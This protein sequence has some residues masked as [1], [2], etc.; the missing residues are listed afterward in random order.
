MNMRI[1]A[2]KQCGKEEIWKE[3]I[4]N[5]FDEIMTLRLPEEQRLVFEATSLRLAHTSGVNFIAPLDAVRKDLGKF[6]NLKMPERYLMMKEIHILFRP[7]SGIPVQILELYQEVGKAAAAYIGGKAKDDITEYLDTLPAEAISERC[8]MMTELAGIMRY[9]P[10][11]SL[12]KS[13]EILLSARDIYETNGLLLA[14]ARVSAALA[15]EHFALENLDDEL[16]PGYRESLQEAM[17]YA[18]QVI[19]KVQLHPEIAEVF[20]QIAWMYV[21]LHM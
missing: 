17:E 13:K 21:R 14:A 1:A 18:E 9:Q 16:M 6:L 8:A 15:D 10:G 20:A 7:E 11:Y 2:A 19:Q 3:R 12:E 4:L 5:G